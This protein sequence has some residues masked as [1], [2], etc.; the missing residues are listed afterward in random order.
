MIKVE[1]KEMYVPNPSTDLMDIIKITWN[2]AAVGYA[3]VIRE[4]LKDAKCEDHPNQTST[5]WILANGEGFDV[6]KDFCCK[7]FSDRIQIDS[8]SKKS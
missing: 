2:K 3:D 1:V 5:V 6:K 7:T 8:T 4:H